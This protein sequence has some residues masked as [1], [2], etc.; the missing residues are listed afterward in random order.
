[1]LISDWIMAKWSSIYLHGCE[2]YSVISESRNAI[3]NFWPSFVTSKTSTHHWSYSEL[4]A[5]Y[6]SHIFSESNRH[7][8]LNTNVLRCRY[9]K[10]VFIIQLVFYL[11]EERSRLSK[12]HPIIELKFT[13]FLIRIYDLIR[14]IIDVPFP[15]LIKNLV[16]GFENQHFGIFWN[17]RSVI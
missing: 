2:V 3:E 13:F 16:R 1:M 4:F 17:S 7:F 11:N 6:L 10:Q 8:G 5:G 14:I 15:I 9:Q 12:F